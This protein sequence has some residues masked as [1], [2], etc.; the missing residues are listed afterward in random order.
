M[1]VVVKHFPIIDSTNTWAKQ[2]A[3]LF[4]RDKITIVVADG[5]TSGRGR[6]NRKWISPAGQNVYMSICFFLHK[7]SSLLV[8]LSN[9]SQ[10]IVVSVAE[11]LEELGFKPTLKWPNDLQLSNRKVAGILSETKVVDDEICFIAGIG[12]NV[13]MPLELLEQIDQPATSLLHENGVE[14]DVSTVSSLV[15]KHFVSHLM[16]FKR[17]GFDPFLE[18][19]RQRIGHKF[20]Q[21][22]QFREHNIQLEGIFHSIANDGALIIKLDHG[23]IKRLYCGDVINKKIK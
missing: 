16:Q 5:Q 11:A 1:D 17:E 12:V 22:I 10:I 20:G 6:L 7:D 14:V 9:M 4:L 8:Q 15:Q 13:N 21:R 23:E 18:K 19:Y 2:N 3:H